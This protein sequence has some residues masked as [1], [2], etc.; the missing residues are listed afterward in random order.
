MDES[1]RFCFLAMA[2]LLNTGGDGGG[3]VGY[4]NREEPIE[5]QIVLEKQFEVVW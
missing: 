5:A 1:N 4:N 2:G 3:E